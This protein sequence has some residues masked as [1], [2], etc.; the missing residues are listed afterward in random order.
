MVWTFVLL[1]QYSPAYVTVGPYLRDADGETARQVRRLAYET[2]SSLS[3][4]LAACEIGLTPTSRRQLTG[5]T[6]ELLARL[7]LWSDLALAMC[8]DSSSIPFAT[9]QPLWAPL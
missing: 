8:V 4:L 2:T 7:K 5:H 9:D 1:L 3:G 6:S